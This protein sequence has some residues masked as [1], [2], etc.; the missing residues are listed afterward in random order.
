MV[1]LALVT[2]RTLLFPLLA[3]LYRISKRKRKRLRD[4]KTG[5]CE[6]SA[7]PSWNILHLDLIMNTFWVFLISGLDGVYCTPRYKKN[8]TKTFN[9]NTFSCGST[10]NIEYLNKWPYTWNMRNIWHINHCLT[11]LVLT[12]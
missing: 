9:Y 1:L 3:I 5:L 7:L 10:W 12:Y 6:L 4:L 8:K 11:S 2:D